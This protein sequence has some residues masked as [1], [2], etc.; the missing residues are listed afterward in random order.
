ML[1][2]VLIH[3]PLDGD[4]KAIGRLVEHSGFRARL[5]ALPTDLEAALKQ[6]GHEAVLL[7]VIS[8]EG[9]N[10]TT[11]RV[12]NG[13][14]ASE[15]SW[16]RLPVVFLV[17]DARRPPAAV[18]MLDRKE[19]A[20]PFMLLERPVR[21]SV[22]TRA[23]QT[24]AE[25]RRRQYETRNLLE[26]LFSEEQRSR[27]LLNELRHRTGNSL[28]L[29][30]ALF[31]LSAR[32]AADI[33][34]LARSFGARLQAV[35]AAQTL[36]MDEGKEVRSLDTLLHEH[37]AP[38]AGTPDQLRLSGTPVVIGGRMAFD[39]AMVTNE[40]ATNAAKYGAL[41]RPEGCVEVSWQVEEETGALRL[42]WRERN[43]PA[44]KRPERS[45]VGARL[46]QRFPSKQPTA[47]V[48]FEPDGLIWRARLPTESFENA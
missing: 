1:P 17:N 19:N 37:V 32:S 34:E 5:C 25:A 41:S 38:Y 28:A 7:C 15:P 2:P 12:L 30:Q 47:E 21:A 11:G 26:K 9:A 39:L 43:G 44:V 46:V 8:Q 14:F 40:L 23:I 13:V 20:P 45:G 42:V 31:N 6:E 3:A 35:A 33:D 24:Q 48:F 4:A 22:L 29:L 18:R 16:A 27:F 36:L 10:E